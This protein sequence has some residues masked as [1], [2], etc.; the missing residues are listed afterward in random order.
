MYRGLDE[1]HHYATYAKRNTK[2]HGNNGKQISDTT[3][4]AVTQIHTDLAYPNGIVQNRL[5][6]CAVIAAGELGTAKVGLQQQVG[7]GVGAVKGM[8]VDL[9]G[10]PLSQLAVQLVLVVAHWQLSIL[11]CILCTKGRRVGA[12]VSR[13]GHS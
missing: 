9:Q 7:L 13:G 8:W 10:E 1:L 12:E 2:T 6:V 11:L 5:S 3:V 4:I